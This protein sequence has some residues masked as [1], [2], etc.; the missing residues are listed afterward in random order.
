MA[1]RFFLDTNLFAYTFDVRSD[2]KRERAQSLVADAMNGRGII[3]YQ[4]V[5]ECL[6]FLLR[7]LARPMSAGEASDYLEKVLMPLCRVMPAS[8]LY[9]DAITISSETGW[10][11]YDSLIVSAAA[12]GGCKILYTE[13]LQPGRVIRG[14]K[15]QNPF[16]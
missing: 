2:A 8:S 6:H 15:I 13:D 14:V 7:K 3:S 1:A 9:V 16:A 12:A 10:T 5:Q 4:V 11:F